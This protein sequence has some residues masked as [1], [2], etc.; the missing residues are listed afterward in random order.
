M[1][2]L[3]RSSRLGLFVSAIALTS[4]PCQRAP[5]QASAAIT[6]APAPAWSRSAVLYEVNVRQYTP[7]G[8]FAA[9]MPHIA[10]LKVLGVD[11]LWLMP[12]QP[13]GVKNR[14]GTL[15]SY[16]SIRNYIAV[17]PEFGTL[18]DVR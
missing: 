14:K 8:T 6:A 5:T 15:G 12:I 11:A 18:A 2:L 16:Y 1:S 17:N 3:L 7:Q 13:I 10:R 4:V 9:L